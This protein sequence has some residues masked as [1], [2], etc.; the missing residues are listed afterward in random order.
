M[1][2]VIAYHY[3]GTPV[4]FGPYRSSKIANEFARR[5]EADTDHYEDTH[6]VELRDWE[7]YNR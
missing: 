3:D 1:K 2:A 6:V 5:T 4:A 7:E